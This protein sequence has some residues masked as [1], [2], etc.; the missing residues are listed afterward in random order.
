[1]RVAWQ[2]I[3]IAPR[4]C[5][6]LTHRFDFCAQ[7]PAQSTLEDMQLGKESKHV[8]EAA[9]RSREASAGRGQTQTSATEKS[10][11][12][13]AGAARRSAA[14]RG[15]CLAGNRARKAICRFSLRAA[16]FLLDIRPDRVDNAPG[17][18]DECVSAAGPFLVG[19]GRSFS[20]PSWWASMHDL[21]M[22]GPL[23]NAPLSIQVWIEK[24]GLNLFSRIRS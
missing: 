15:S 23:T 5:E 13:R 9:S 1:M 18:F 7:A 24:L 14:A 10:R 21:S 6:R 12:P 19:S 11:R 2:C 3:F 4:A 20:R 22:Y 17:W 8:R 16:I